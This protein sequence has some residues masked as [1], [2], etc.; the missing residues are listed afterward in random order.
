MCQSAS[1]PNRPGWTGISARSAARRTILITAAALVLTACADEG[2]GAPVTVPVLT[3][4]V[5]EPQQT[6]IGRRVAAAGTIQ[7][8]QEVSIGAEVGGYR[9]AEL[10]ADVGDRVRR[11]QVLAR[12]DTAVLEAD[13]RELEAAAAEARASLAEAEANADRARS[14]KA[15]GTLSAREADQL[16]TGGA[17][18]RARLQAAEARLSAGRLRLSF[19]EVRATDDGV[20]AAR[21]ATPGQVVSA[22]TEL[23]RLV[24]RG[25]LEWRAE[26]Q[27]RDFA[28]IR[29]GLTA[30]LDGMSGSTT[31][32]VR[33]V[34]PGIDAGTRTGMAYIDLP[35]DSP[36][37]AGMFAQ[38]GIDVGSVPGLTVPAKAL[39]Q[40]D[41]F[42]YLFALRPD[43]TV[44]QR[45][46]TRGTTA[47]GRIE[48][49][50]GLA[51]A[52][53]VV[54]DG[55]G[56]LRDGDAVRLAPGGAGP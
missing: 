39:V 6:D 25:R 55:A 50:S 32:R 18:A 13:L 4:S 12:L 22:G 8:W 42:D 9:L 7:P 48:I 19:T 20:I 24:R 41:G 26:I 37:R 53:R 40:R 14:L 47:D 56:F 15:T 49:V 51:A 38:G 21:S 52:D 29:P 5:A 11:G 46:V 54:V 36:L 45:R 33:T 44:E 16:I 1:W 28:R 35:A 3:V 34:S 27:E 31:G 30:T 23:F 2:G 17:T 10:R 43:G